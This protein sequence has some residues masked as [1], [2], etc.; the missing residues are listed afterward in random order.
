M[1]TP[2]DTTFFALSDP[3]RRAILARLAEGPAA[4]KDLSAPFAISAPA[5]TKHLDVLE[6]A[7]LIARGRDAQRRPCMLRPEALHAAFDWFLHY[8]RFWDQTTDRL[9]EFLNENPETRHD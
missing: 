9:E 4:V 3:T 1:M 8:T 2:L 5:I 7:G 6:R